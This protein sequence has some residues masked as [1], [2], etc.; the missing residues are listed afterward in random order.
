MRKFRIFLASVLGPII[1][2][3][4][5]NVLLLFLMWLLH[6]L[7]KVSFLQ[8]LESKNA[9]LFGAI[10]LFLAFDCA[11]AALPAAAATVG[12]VGDE[13]P[14]PYVAAGIII[15][16]IGAASAILNLTHGAFHLANLVFPSMGA[17][18]ISIRK[19]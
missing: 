16:V 10:Q 15:I 17:L 13:E 18:L 9:I 7:A 8:W 19:G 5:Y 3:L 14:A 12:T 6:L 11:A 1:A 4:V 2:L